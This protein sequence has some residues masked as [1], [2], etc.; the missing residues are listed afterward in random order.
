MIQEFINKLNTEEYISN[1]LFEYVQEHDSSV[2]P[3]GFNLDKYNNKVMDKLL[4][5]YKDYFNHQYDGISNIKLDNEQ[6]RA[7][8][9]DEKY[10]LIVAGAGTGKTTT[11]ASKVKYLV[12]IKRVNPEKILVL[13]YGRKATEE[14][15]CRINVDFEIPAHVCTF[16]SLGYSYIRS[17]YKDR[18]CIVVDH[19]KRNEIFL[20]YFKMLHAREGAIDEITS[21]FGIIKNLYKYLFGIFYRDNYYNYDTYDEFFEAYVEHKLIETRNIGAETSWKE[22]SRNQLTKDENIRSIRGE[23]VKSAGEAV[24]ANILFINNVDYEYE[25]PYDS[26]M[27]ENKIYKPDFTVNFGTEKIYIEYFGLN[28]PSYNRIKEKKIK[29]H[30]S[31]NNKFIALE[32]MS[33][34]DLGKKLKEQL[35]GYGVKFKRMLDIKICEHI[36]RLNPLSQVFHFEAFLYKCI[37]WIKDSPYRNNVKDKIKDY[38]R[39]LNPNSNEYKNVSVQ[40]KYIIEF[41]NFYNDKL[42]GGE[43]YYLDYSDMLYY[44]NKYIDKIT[45]DTHK[46]D[47]VIIDEY[48]D[49]SNLRYELLKHTANRN[50]SKIFAVGDDWQSIFSFAGSRIEYFYN[51]QKSFKGAKLFK[52]N[53]T[54]RNCQELI[55]MAGEFIMRNKKQ[56]P[57]TLV[58][59]KHLNNPIILKSYNGKMYNPKTKKVTPDPFAEIKCLR[60]TLIEIHSKHPDYKILVI[61]RYNSNID[62]VLDDNSEFVNGLNSNVVYKSYDSY[63]NFDIMSIHKSKGLTYDVVIVIG[64]S[65]SFPGDRE[66]EVWVEELFKEK[67]INEGIA[68]PEERR[69]LYVALTRTKNKVILIYDE[70][71]KYRSGFVNE[72]RDIIIYHNKGK[73]FDKHNYEDTL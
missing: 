17:I 68:Y 49:I 50:D 37:D 40:A 56:I 30:K 36:I 57:K 69:V 63:I 34:N 2:I 58:S 13:S 12:D 48:Q 24:I 64:L 7:I 9:S 8:V 27:E 14:L 3:T 55:D 23:Y 43:D 4:Y 1:H 20:E 21:H 26:Y 25:E 44:S 66:N 38:L 10:A 22:W 6:R 18:K 45:T 46:Y 47:Y 61:S 42:L 52:I 15:V 33:F 65:K 51:F 28:D 54:H 32:K 35:E 60:D 19:N 70:N 16:H 67:E 62:N 39:T 11:M 5:E 53:K 29:Y 41:Y 31:H 73:N 71:P 72:I 59:D